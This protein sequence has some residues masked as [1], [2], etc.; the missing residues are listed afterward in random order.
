[1]A[2]CKE[3]TFG[4]L[5]PVIEFDTEAQVLDMAND[6]EFGLA[7]YVFTRD[8]ARAQRAIMALQF[9]HVGWNTGSGPTPEAPFGGIKQSGFG[10]EGGAEGIYEFAEAQTVPRGA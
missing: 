5:V 1:M 4:P 8:E 3:E 10:R 6:T 2:C 9:Q 7:A